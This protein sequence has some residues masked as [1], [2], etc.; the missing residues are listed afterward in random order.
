MAAQKIDFVPRME[1][2]DALRGFALFGLFIVHMPEL[3]ELYWA[4]PVKDPVQLLWHDTVFTVFAGKAFALLAMCF[5]VSFFIIMDRSA[6][7]GKDFTGRFIWRLAVL[8]I[9]GLV[10]G[11]WYRGDVLEV[12]AVMGLFLLP[13]YRLKSNAAVM[14]LGLLFL[15]QPIMIFQMISAL[16][17]AEWANKPFSFWS[18]TTPEAYLTGKSLMEAIRMNWVDGHPFKWAFMYES[19]RLSQILGLSL[20]GMVLG[21]INFFGAPEKFGKTRIIGFVVALIAALALWHTRDMLTN[22]M[23]T[24]EKVFMPRSLWG[25]MVSGWFDLSVMFSLF[26]GFTAL[27]YSFAGKALNVLAP[28]GRMTLTLYLLQSLIF[29]PV[30][31]SFGLG[32]HAT[33]TQSEAVLIGLAAFA[34]Q[35]VFAHLWFKGFVYGPVEWLWRAATYLTVKVPFVRKGANDTSA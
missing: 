26:F 13:F 9:I 3:F 28:A 32:L 12:L 29:V 17:G 21:R 4:H 1:G 10:H 5:G 6:Q 2:L 15:L 22:L 24:S 30:F 19:G 31:Y 18:G 11:L 20:I 16:G 23:P 34:V 27:Y 25:S 35:V 7:K 14:V 8:G 33:M